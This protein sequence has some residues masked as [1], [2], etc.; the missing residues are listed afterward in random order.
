MCFAYERR[1][2]LCKLE[3]RLLTVVVRLRIE[4]LWNGRWLPQGYLEKKEISPVPDGVFRFPSEREVFI[5]V[6]SAYRLATGIIAD[7]RQ[8]LRWKCGL[9]LV[10]VHRVSIFE[11]LKK[12]LSKQKDL[13][14][15]L[16]VVLW[17]ELENSAPNVWTVNGP[18]KFFDR[19]EW[20]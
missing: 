19:R 18:I 12:Y 3:N 7:V 20:Q 9:A 17:S 6:Q 14:T 5:R 16:G 13:D 10:V 2:D 8:W 15:P 11:L 1:L 4:E